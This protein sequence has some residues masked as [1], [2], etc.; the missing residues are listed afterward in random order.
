MI[1]ESEDSFNIEVAFA[2]VNRAL[3]AV[4]GK[5]THDGKV[6][7]FTLDLGE[8]PQHDTDIYLTIDV[9][10]N[11]LSESGD[12]VERVH[13]SKFYASYVVNR[14]NDKGTA[15]LKLGCDIDSGDGGKVKVKY[16]ITA[17]GIFD[18]RNN[19]ADLSLTVNENG[20]SLF[21]AF[22]ECKMED[23]ASSLSLDLEKVTYKSN[24]KDTDVELPCD[25]KLTLY[26]IYFLWT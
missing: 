26:M 18:D 16:D 6:V 5:L 22:V 15:T 4:V 23:K 20:S 13:K 17:K 21:D 25:I 7:K 14:E 11:I 2:Y 24:G 12:K 10:E 9:Q 3:S 19:K 1:D 8:D